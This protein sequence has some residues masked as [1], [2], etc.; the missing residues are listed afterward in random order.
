MLDLNVASGT[1][2]AGS[3]TFTGRGTLRKTGA[4]E[5]RWGTGIAA[6]N[7]G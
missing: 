6:F 4:G 1:R 3:T 7:F 5:L 2:D